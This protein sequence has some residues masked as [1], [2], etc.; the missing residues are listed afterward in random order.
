MIGIGGVVPT[1][2]ASVLI[3]GYPTLKRGANEQCA[4]GAVV[5]Q[6]QLWFWKTEWGMSSVLE[7]GRLDG[8]GIGLREREAGIG[9][10]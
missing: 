10:W 5:T 7:N 9:I 2:L 8:V 6:V 4:S 1:G 3:F